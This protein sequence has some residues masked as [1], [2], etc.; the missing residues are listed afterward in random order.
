MCVHREK[1]VRT[2]QGSGH[3]QA[4]ETSGEAHLMTPDDSQPPDLCGNEFL[5]FKPTSLW[6]FV[7]A[8]LAD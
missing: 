6:H 7:M 3:L 1:I 4:K 8:Y 5:L 2:Q